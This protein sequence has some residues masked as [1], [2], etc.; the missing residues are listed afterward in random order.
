MVTRIIV[1]STG[2]HLLPSGRNGIRHRSEMKK[3]QKE[4]DVVAD[5]QSLKNE[6]TN[7]PALCTG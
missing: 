1:V 3:N 6:R 5:L 4:R 2:D 7:A